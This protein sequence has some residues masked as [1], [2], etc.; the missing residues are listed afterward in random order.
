M[1]KKNEII[2]VKFLKENVDIFLSFKF[3]RE[4]IFTCPIIL[5]L[6]ITVVSVS[7]WNCSLPFIPLHLLYHFTTIYRVDLDSSYDFD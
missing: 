1:K 5:I 6:H 3:K 7:K 2:F 4:C